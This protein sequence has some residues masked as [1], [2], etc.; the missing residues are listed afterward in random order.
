MDAR[1]SQVPSTVDFSFAATHGNGRRYI[2]NRGASTLQSRLESASTSK[3]VAAVMIMRVVEQGYL[4][5]SAMPQDYIERWPID[6]ADPMQGMTLSHLLSMTS[7]FTSDPTCV[8]SPTA[9]FEDCVLEI[10]ASNVHGKI[11]GEQFVYASAHHQVAGLMAVKARR[12]PGWSALFEEFK[13]QTG[14]FGQSDFDYPSVANPLLAGG[15]HVTGEDYLAFLDAL[16]AGRLLNAASMQT[17]LTDH[18]ASSV[19]AYSPMV[20]GING[21]PGLGEDWHY[22][23]GLWHEC[24]S[25]QFNCVAGMRVSS[26]GQ[27]GAYPFWDRSKDYTGIVFRQGARGTMTEGI[28]IERAIRSELEQW[29]DCA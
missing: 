27:Y 14:L 8:D 2:F 19:M 12:L 23:F 4:S 11:P 6:A 21:G 28:E 10:A 15:M 26:P 29:A 24:R 16:Q 18:T 7:G 25:A 22:G 13:S 1:L 3:L 20:S 17:L 5:L 9:S